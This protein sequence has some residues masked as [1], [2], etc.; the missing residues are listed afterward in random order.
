[1]FVLGAL[2]VLGRGLADPVEVP[3]AVAAAGLAAALAL[4][5]V[6]VDETDEAFA[7][8]YSAAVSTQNLLPRVPQRLLIALA[9][10]TA[11]GAAIGI[12]LIRYEDFLVLLGSFFVP[13][14]GVLLA[15]WLLARRYSES[16]V[17]GAPA[18]RAGPVVAWLAGFAFYQWLH[19]IGPSW[20]VDLLENTNPPGLGIGATLPSFALSVLL[21]GTA[22]AFTKSS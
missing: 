12:D 21:A 18:F 2:L 20:W 16:D 9:A 19:P 22:R 7:N 8:V 1:M 13:L 17:F 6:T 14:F 10:A 3:A 11:T 15:D 4:L 5:A